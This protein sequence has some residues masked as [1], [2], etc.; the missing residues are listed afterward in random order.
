MVRCLVNELGADVDLADNIGITPLYAAAQ[1]GH[2][3]TV[4]CLVNELGADVNLAT[5]AGDTPL[6][7]A[8]LNMHEEIVRFLMRHGADAQAANRAGVTATYFSAAFEPRSEQTQYLQAKAHCSNPACDGVGAVKCIGCR[9]ARYCGQPCQR[10]HWPEHK[11][12]CRGSHPAGAS[13]SSSS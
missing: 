3:D 11:R 4:P 10:A 8:A 6:H 7:V 2:L 1:H 13:S 9:T 5:K 12:E